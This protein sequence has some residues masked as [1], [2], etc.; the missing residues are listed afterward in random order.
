MA[1]L[2]EIAERFF[3]LAT[4]VD[5]L[6]DDVGEINRE[7]KEIQNDSLFSRQEK[8]LSVKGLKQLQWPLFK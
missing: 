3:T 6:I 2:T 8:K 1:N 7:L 4:K 5:R